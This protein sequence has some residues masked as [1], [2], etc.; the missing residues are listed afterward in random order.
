MAGGGMR[1]AGISAAAGLVALDSMVERLADDHASAQRLARGLAGLP[2][3]ALDPAD[4]ETNIC[5][6]ELADEGGSALAAALK[7][8]SVLAN[9]RHN[10]VRFVTHHGITS[11]D[12][13]EAL[14]AIASVVG[15][16]AVVR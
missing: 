1:Q 12:V 13:D 9:G 6:V 10:W 16:K 7:E 4:V 2:G 14:D 11:E 15:D 3:I 8:R 5:Y